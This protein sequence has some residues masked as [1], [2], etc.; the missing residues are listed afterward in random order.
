MQHVALASTAKQCLVFKDPW[1][2]KK[3]EESIG[4][5][6]T[7]MIIKELSFI[8]DLDNDPSSPYS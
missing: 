8:L 2:K 5:E 7:V 4:K 3:K 1:G 6:L